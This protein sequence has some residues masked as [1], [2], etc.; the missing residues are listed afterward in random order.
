MNTQRRRVL[1]FTFKFDTSVLNLASIY[2]LVRLNLEHF[3]IPQHDLIMTSSAATSF[4]YVPRKVLDLQDIIS[5]RY[6]STVARLEAVNLSGIKVLNYK[7]YYKKDFFWLYDC[8][9]YR[10]F[11]YD[12]NR[13]N[14]GK[15][16]D[17]PTTEAAFYRVVMRCYKKVDP[18][19]YTRKFGKGKERDAIHTMLYKLMWEASLLISSA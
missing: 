18:L 2:F 19:L 15:V 12:L 5:T 7:P 4:A 1:Q 3:N 14:S 9:G 16:L 11:R 8:L 6:P 13:A 17:R 10:S